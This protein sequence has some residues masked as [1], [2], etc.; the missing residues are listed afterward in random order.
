MDKSQTIQQFLTNHIPNIPIAEFVTNLVIALVLVFLVQAVYVRF[1][2]ALSNRRK[3]ASNFILLGLTTMIIITVVKSSL[4]LS[5]GLVGALSIVRFRSAI[6]EPEELSYVFLTIAIGLGLGAGQRA[7]TT[8][9]TLFLLI[10]VLLK[11]LR[12]NSEPS[13]NLYLR[14]LT[15]E[16][17]NLPLE[18]LVE[19][20]KKSCARVDIKRFDQKVNLLEA[21]FLI[22]FR[23]VEDLEKMRTSLVALDQGLEI[24]F[25]DHKLT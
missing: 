21:V 22:E 20:L 6:K 12:I 9:G 5:L 3:F 14:C 23:S 2:Q 7:V 13:Q 15:R 24:S 11:Y 8:I 10:V 19:T 25:L 1:G 17:G 16:T 4:A 18:K